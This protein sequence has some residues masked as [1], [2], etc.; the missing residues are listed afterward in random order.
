MAEI[1]SNDSHSDK[2]S[3]GRGLRHYAEARLRRAARRGCEIAVDAG[4]PPPCVGYRHVRPETARDHVARVQAE[5]RRP[6]SWELVHPLARAS[7]PLPINV[8][9]RD[10]LPDDAGWWGYSMRDVPERL[11]DETFIATIPDGRIVS[12]VDERKEFYPAILTGD[13][14]AVNL[15]EIVFRNRHAEIL[16]TRPPVRKLARATWICERVY[17]NHSHWLTAHLPKLCLLRERGA[18]GDVLLPER[19]TKGM[20]SSLRLMGLDPEAFTRFKP[21]ELLQV[22]ELTFLGTDRFRGELLRPVREAMMP[23]SGS[24]PSR[25]VFISR[26]KARMRRLANEDEIWPLFADAGFE[27]FC[28]EDLDFAAQVKLMS[29]TA[30]LAAP[31]GAGLTNQ[32]FC[33]SGAH[34]LEIAWLGFPNPN[35]YALAS[36]M[37][38]RYA[39]VPAEPYGDSATLLERDMVVDAEAIRRGLDAL[40][41]SL[42]AGPV[43]VGT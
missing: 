5:G 10:N 8:P 15:R 3:G 20:E 35:F 19:L 1:S 30:V 7:N 42:A 2:P 11:S 24:A 16:R 12:Y 40:E 36:A 38:H 39:L 14:R 21:G 37:G 6:A 33:P 26:A 9:D 32:M 22:A 23:A 25:R 43:Q 17:D 27:R 41:R 13:S 31:H 4:L 29:E 28:M 18:L 34:V